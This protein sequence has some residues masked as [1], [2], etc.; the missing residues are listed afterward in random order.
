MPSIK[1]YGWTVSPYSAKTRSYLQYK[2]IPFTDLVP[3]LRMLTGKIERDVGQMIMPVVYDGQQGISDSTVI[4][5]Y[6]EQ[7]HPE[8]P[9][10]PINPKQHITTLLIELFAD[11]WLPLAALH[12][13]WNYPKNRPFILKEFGKS[14]LPWL[15]GFIQKMAAKRVASRMSGYLPILG[16]SD[17]MTAPLERNTETLMTILDHHLQSSD[18]IFGSQ[19]TLADFALFGPL[20]AHLDRDPHP[21]NLVSKH[22]DLKRWIERM[23]GDFSEVRAQQNDQDRDIPDSLLPLLGMIANTILPLIKQSKAAIDTWCQQHPDAEKLPRK[24]GHCT[25]SI[26]E[27]EEKRLNLTYPYW[28]FQRITAVFANLS[29]DDQNEL[30]TWFDQISP[31]FRSL[32]T[33][34]LNVEVALRNNRLWRKKPKADHTS[35]VAA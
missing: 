13:R 12:Y 3:S 10:I 28:M 21:E 33:A 15:P 2:N 5:E 26:E 6:F 30:L 11:E 32:L 31:E 29:A 17:K 9:V 16:I 19:P 23:K 35:N 1:H 25:L 14:A 34:P 22:T 8:K 4:I 20:W 7:T 18:F 24:I 27:A